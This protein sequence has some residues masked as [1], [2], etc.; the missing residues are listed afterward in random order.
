MIRSTHATVMVV[1]AT[2]L[3]LVGCSHP[4]STAPKSW[5]AKSATVYL[6]QREVAWRN[7]PGAARDH[8][9]FCISCHT[10]LP[11]VLSRPALRAAVAEQ[12]PS[13]DELKILT[14]VRERV[15]L[16]SQT[17]P[18]YKDAGY[19]DGKP[20]QS[21]G[22][23]AVLNA[24]IL[25]NHD[26]QEHK[27]SPET[28]TAFHIMWT[29]Q[30]T[31]GDAKGSWEWL[32][33]GMEPWEANDSAYYGATLAAI[34]VGMAP[35]NYRA[36]PEIQPQLNL[37]H[38][39]LNREIKKQSTINRT[40]L[41]WAGMELPGL[42]NAEKQA[43]IIKELRTQQRSDGGWELSSLSWPDDGSLHSLIRSHLRWDWSRQ[44]TRSDG[45]ATALITYVLGQA[46]L[47]PNDPTLRRGLAWLAQNENSDGSWT[48]ASLSKK[49]DPSSMP[50]H[51]M[52][53]AATAYA[54]LALTENRIPLRIE[55][56]NLSSLLQPLA[57]STS[58]PVTGRGR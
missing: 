12:A 19:G 5:D 34:A 53:D 32:R 8:G 25:A 56:S 15:R 23:E 49:R 3:S 11:Y 51:F 28:E 55:P 24:L 6:D 44:D 35:E 20:A 14:D 4:Q 31:E 18:Y 7:W 37:L 46:G 22:T 54:V 58:R 2:L 29:L 57:R 50:G 13:N 17:E 52:R 41:L 42:I 26:E 16:W 48:S 40:D 27:L 10:V 1:S 43:A 33:F 39:Y 36:R 21:R 38:E 47:S 45:Y 9:T 30:Q